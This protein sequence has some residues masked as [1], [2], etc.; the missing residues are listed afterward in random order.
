M[1]V[2][3]ADAITL[4]VLPSPSYVRQFYLLQ[5]A[6]LAVPAVPTTNPPAA[7][8]STTEPNYTPTSTD[9]L[10]TVMLTAYGSVAFE[11]GPVQ[12]SSSYEAAKQAYNLAAQANTAA[13]NAATSADGKGKIVYGTT[14]PAV[15]DRNDKTIWFDETGGANTPKKWN[16]TAWVSITDKVALDAA[17]AA[18]TAATAAEVARVLASGK[19]EV[20][21]S[22][23]TP[24]ASDE[25]SA[26]LWIN[27]LN[28]LNTPNRFL[29][30]GTPHNST[31]SVMDSFGIKR[32]NLILNPSFEL[33]GAAVVVRTNLYTDPL[34]TTLKPGIN[35]A[36]TTYEGGK[37]RTVTPATTTV[38]SGV[39]LGAPS[40]TAAGW[41]TYSV[42]ITAITAD[43][44]NLSVQGS[45]G[46]ANGTAVFAAGETKRLS[47]SVNH[48]GAGGVA[49][50][51]L[52]R[53]A[54]V[55]QT[56]DVTNIMVEDYWTALPF[57]SGAS[58]AGDDFTYNWVA[59]ANASASQQKALSVVNT[60]GGN[61]APIQSTN[62]AKNGSKSLRIIPTSK[63]A[64]L[65]TYA[66]IELLP[67]LAEGK[68][69]TIFGT[70]R[71]ATPQTGGTSGISQ[72]R[73]LF[74]DINGAGGGTRSY[75]YTAQS[76]NVAG[77]Y[78]HRMTFTVP[79]VSGAPVLSLG[80][81]LYNGTSAGE[82]Y[83]DSLMLV[84][85]TYTGSY[86]DGDFPGGYWGSG[87]WVNVTDK[88]ASDAAA[89]A[90]LANGR[91]SFST[92]APLVADGAGKPTG[93]VW[94]QK[95]GTGNVIGQWEWTGVAWAVRAISH[96][97]IASLDAAK[98]T[99]GVL[100]AARIAANSISTAKLAI[101]DMSNMATVN[102]TYP[103][104]VNYS[105]AGHQIVSGWSSRVNNSSPFFMFRD[106]TGPLPFKTGERLR[107]TF[108]A[109][110]A[111]PL[112]V[113]LNLWA[114]DSAGANISQPLASA[115]AITATP[116]AFSGEAVVTIDT[117]G[118]RTFLLGL[119]NVANVAV[120]VRNVRVYRMNAGE[121]LVDGSIIAAK[122]A[123]GTITAESGVIGSIDAAKITVGFLQSARIAA[124]SISTV[125]LLVGN[126]NNLLE[127]PGF[128][129]NTPAAWNNGTTNVTKVT[130]TPR[131]GLYALRVKATTAAYEAS[132]HQA[133]IPVEPG[134]VYV[135]GAWVRA[136]GTGASVDGAIEL[137]VVSGPT[138]AT[139]ADLTAVADSPVV[140]ATYVYTSGEW[141]VPAGTKFVRPRIVS[142]TDLSN[143]NSYLIDDMTFY[144]KV[145][146]SLIVDGSITSN[147]IAAKAITASK[148]D[149][150][151]VTAESMA[152]NAVTFGTIAAGAV[153][154]NEIASDSIL[155]NHI[156]VGQIS[157]DHL[158]ANVGRELNITGNDSVNIIVGKI[159]TVTAAQQA[160]AG[161]LQSMQTYYKFGPSGAVIA[162]PGSPFSVALRS[163][164]IEMLEQNVP[165]SYWNA[166][167]MFVRSFV[168][169]EVVLGN[170]K[171]EKYL[172]GT[173]VR[174]L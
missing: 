24:G 57:F 25:S 167:Q 80:V 123:T 50:Y 115:V 65:D 119:Q 5:P 58:A 148:I 172:T 140:G 73:N 23:T 11:Y 75:G 40:T 16:G 156:K 111:T 88:V 74:L 81:R 157:T 136:E 149:A 14:A 169:E 159:D 130:T 113:P 144:R 163:D 59:G 62:W 165:V 100:D 87:S 72:G 122:I 128:E 124:N 91:V 34:G 146:G 64:A 155:A 142:R 173:V 71:L 1:T 95:D 153:R 106:Q 166:G 120:F 4:A 31:S 54:N 29:G 116:T 52:R 37:T 85:G 8:W 107:F 45:V 67:Q 101:G 125:Q 131:T 19:G 103:D 84:E 60:P 127:D 66:R 141:T 21:Y 56:F 102:E 90:V 143:V 68:T 44:Y 104:S 32:T 46:G 47:V 162:S 17:T 132:R 38:D 39:N 6:A 70:L 28:G 110:A 121:L 109:Y 129:S 55:S 133:A 137:S 151:A 10:Y 164:R 138:S 48:T 89:S 94:W 79:A 13:S 168:G 22:P 105:N 160:T 134:E 69:Y 26:N 42:E 27:T 150:K 41:R 77:E 145:T 82:V 76:P 86:V 36:T 98:I 49:L 117:T 83:W 139:S 147:N 114:Y 112:T 152:A 93:A 97:T 33:A 35:G 18:A 20:I 78:E 170:H 174:A 9:T 92:L 15:A 12:K 51:V 61:C 43:T 3:A 154:A 96:Q 7:P 161:S 2:R 30:A 118:R 158:S 126:F 53:T 135:F 171:L 99:V 63:G 108:E